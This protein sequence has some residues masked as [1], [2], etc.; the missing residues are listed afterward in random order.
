MYKVTIIKPNISKKENEK[1][2]KRLEE[3]LQKVSLQ[4]LQR[5]QKEGEEYVIP[6]GCGI[7]LIK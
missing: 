4:I 7:R 5:I 6:K 1:N 2:L 3:V